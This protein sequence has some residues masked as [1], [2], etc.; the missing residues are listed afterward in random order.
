[1]TSARKLLLYATILLASTVAGAETPAAYEY[2]V[3]SVPLERP[4]CD[5]PPC[6]LPGMS[7]AYQKIVEDGWQIM[8]INDDSRGASLLWVRRARSAP[9]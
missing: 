5:H 6:R 8:S 3:F 9:K 4:A 2:A 1:M 7:S